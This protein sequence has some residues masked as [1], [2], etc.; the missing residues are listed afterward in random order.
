MTTLPVRVAAPPA[1]PAL[2]GAR[3]ELSAAVIATL[4]GAR[5]PLPRDLS[6][7]D[8]WGADL[9][10]AL[11]L[12]YELHYQGF[13]DVDDRYE[14]DPELLRLRAA[15]E[16]RFLTALRREVTPGDDVGGTLAEL[17]LEPVTDDGNSISHFLHRQGTWWQ[18]REYTVLR[19]PYHLKEA[20]PHVWVVPRLRGRAK[21]AMVAIE[22]DE[23]GAGRA[24]AVHAELFAALMRDLGLDS[25]YGRYL[26]AAPAP[27]LA[28]V[29][30]MSLLG[31]HRSLRG[32]L[33][34]H[35]AAVEVTSSP[36]SRR[37]AAAL[38]RLGAGPAAVRFHDEH[39]E[40]DAVHEQVVRHE[41]V[42][43]LLEDEPGLAADVV[44]GI[45]ATSH[46]EERLARWTLAA[47][48]AGRSA[49]C[50]PLEASPDR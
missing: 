27:A 31:L 39:V 30:L 10:L 48:R 21:A 44:F 37:M 32:A 35:F 1:G 8:P 18:V 47:W 28:T 36:G 46:L 23:Y 12:L 9:Q 26:D 43:G 2:P 34:G 13:A 24:E 16:D 38:R 29:N 42:G 20:D 7:A 3:G 4:R 14:W 22:Y 11:Y 6:G 19:S 17:L 45:R 25:G 15:A 49:L 5:R 40:A 41:V 33:V 50:R